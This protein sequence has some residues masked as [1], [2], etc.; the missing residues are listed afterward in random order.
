MVLVVL[1]SVPAP[2]TWSGTRTSTVIV[3]ESKQHQQSDS[4]DLWVG[5][6]KRSQTEAGAKVGEE[7]EGRSRSFTHSK[8]LS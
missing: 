8:P 3:L 6:S 5:P 7:G 4:A 1:A 2:S